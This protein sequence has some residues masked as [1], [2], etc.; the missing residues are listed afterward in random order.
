MMHTYGINMRY[1]GKIVALLDSKSEYLHMR[2]VVTRA[3]F[4]RSLKHYINEI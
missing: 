1:M 4:V 3:I 2:M